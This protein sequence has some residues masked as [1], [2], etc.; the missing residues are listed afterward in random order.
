MHKRTKLVGNGGSHAVRVPAENRFEG[1]G[2]HVWRDFVA[3]RDRMRA[4]P[5]DFLSDRR[6]STEERDAP[7]LRIGR[8]GIV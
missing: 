2:I 1:T 5:E 8:Q 4:M 7:G 3:L 6:Q